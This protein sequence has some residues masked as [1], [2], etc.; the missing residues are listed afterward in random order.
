M[1]SSNLMD[2]VCGVSE[3]PKSVNVF[4]SPPGTRMNLQ[5]K[6]HGVGRIQGVTLHKVKSSLLYMSFK[7]QFQSLWD[8]SWRRAQLQLPFL[9]RFLPMS[10]KLCL[11]SWSNFFFTSAVGHLS[12]C[13]VKGQQPSF[14]LSYLEA[15][16][17]WSIGQKLYIHCHAPKCGGRYAFF[18]GCLP[19]HTSLHTP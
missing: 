4:S 6:S 2:C 13:R 7:M 9:T 18:K 16:K 14:S 1:I 17:L 12:Y 8:F 10:I 3:A 15:S 11:H 19:V 5:A